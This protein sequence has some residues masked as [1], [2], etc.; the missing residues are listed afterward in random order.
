MTTDTLD[1]K[2]TRFFRKLG[3]RTEVHHKD[4]Q[5]ASGTRGYTARIS[6]ARK[7]LKRFGL[8][9]PRARVVRRKVRGRSVVDSYYRVERA[10]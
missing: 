8:V 7:A 5:W 9:I 2:V 3:T 1:E 10:K 6:Y 4:L